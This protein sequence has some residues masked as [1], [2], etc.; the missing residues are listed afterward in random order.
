[1]EDA[2]TSRG[3]QRDPPDQ[4]L[5][6]VH[7][8]S[9]HV[10]RLGPVRRRDHLVPPEIHDVHKGDDSSIETFPQYLDHAGTSVQAQENRRGCLA[11]TSM[12]SPVFDFCT[13][14]ALAS[15]K[16]QVNGGST[17][18]LIVE[19]DLH[20]AARRLRPARGEADRRCRP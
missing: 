9:A 6:R 12:S 15:R 4:M 11:V 17:G 8:I 13:A 20:V 2:F 7:P 10:V 5:K 18:D 14:R 1:L 19:V 3:A 16:E